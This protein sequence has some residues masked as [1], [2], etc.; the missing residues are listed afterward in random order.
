MHMG[1]IYMRGALRTSHISEILLIELLLE[2]YLRD[3]VVFSVSLSFAIIRLVF[4]ENVA[5]TNTR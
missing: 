3:C 1:M 4:R 5:F 2:A